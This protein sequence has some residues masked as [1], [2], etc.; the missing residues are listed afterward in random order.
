M[1]VG[2][3]ILAA[4]TNIAEDRLYVAL[5][6]GH[7]LMHAAQGISCLVMIEL[8]DRTDWPPRVCGMA[9]LAWDIQVPMRAMSPARNLCP[10]RGIC[11]ARQH[12]YRDE[13]EYAPSA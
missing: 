12:K 7:G 5:R 1:N 13:F 11:R 2:V 4:L 10:C 9:V 8:W 6:T 3:A